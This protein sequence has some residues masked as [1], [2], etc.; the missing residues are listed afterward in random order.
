MMFTFHLLI[1]EFDLEAD[2]W[3]AAAAYNCFWGIFFGLCLAFDYKNEVF[4]NTL[5]FWLS[6]FDVVTALLLIQSTWK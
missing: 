3:A 5:K 6:L 1:P 2:P 4:A